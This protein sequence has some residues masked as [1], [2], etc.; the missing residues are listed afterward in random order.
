MLGFG[1]ALQIMSI[2]LRM[3]RCV[4][5]GRCSYHCR[6]R[7]RAG[8]RRSSLYFIVPASLLLTGTALFVRRNSWTTLLKC[9][10]YPGL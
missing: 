7:S 10:A 3:R 1:L 4:S 5:G 2:R 9:C 6:S 8:I